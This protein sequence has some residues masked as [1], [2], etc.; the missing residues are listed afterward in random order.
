MNKINKTLGI[1][2]ARFASTRFPGKVL[3]DIMGKPM[4]QHV[5]EQALQATELHE[6]VVATDSP[7]VV[8][9]VRAFGGNVVLT[10]DS[11]QSGTDRCAEVAA[12]DAFAAFATIVNIQGDEPFIQPIQI[13][14]L[15][16]FL[17]QN[18]QFEI[19]TLA[20]KITDRQQLFSPNCVKVVFSA[21]ANA[22][23]FSRNAIP[24]LRDEQLG[25]WLKKGDFYKH[26]GLYAYRSTTLQQIAQLPVALLEQQEKLEQLRWLANGY[27]IGIAETKLETINIDSPEDLKRI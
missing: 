11:H 17:N 2:P 19:A 7:K 14:K 6:L 24:Y 27:K 8:N 3:V 5:Y 21:T 18:E 22:L 16:Q 4:I 13:N 26:I 20:K 25:N 1:I 15:A 9:A 12:L 10:S 23:Y